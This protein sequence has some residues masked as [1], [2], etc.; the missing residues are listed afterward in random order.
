MND[1]IALADSEWRLMQIVWEKAPCTFRQICDAACPAYGWTKHAV[2]SYLKRMEAKGAIRA[3]DAKPVRL[4]VPLLDRGEAVREET[5]DVLARVYNGNVL[6]MMQSAARAKELT[7][8]ELD[9]LERLLRE[10]RRRDE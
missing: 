9:A 8:A 3:E 1:H 10:G 2:I 6:L 7:D 5:E 4:Y